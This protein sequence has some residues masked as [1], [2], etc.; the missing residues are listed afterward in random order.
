MRRPSPTP[1]CSRFSSARAPSIAAPSKQVH[2]L[3]SAAPSTRMTAGE[4]AGAASAL[5]AGVP[6]VVG[7]GDPVMDI[8]ARV[9]PEWLATVAPEAG[10]CIPIPPG[11]M[12]EL[13]SSAGR[14][15]ELLRW[16]A[17]YRGGGGVAQPLYNGGTGMRP[18]S[19]QH[20]VPCRPGVA[21]TAACA[22]QPNAHALRQC[23]CGARC[24]CC[25]I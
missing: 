24:L 20:A 11:P 22:L 3:N 25:R 2:N 17:V 14:Q 13:V 5:G 15:S 23:C 16:V 21:G 8:L 18:S 9:T 12:S 10:G 1:N 19:T 7:L 6:T 4:H